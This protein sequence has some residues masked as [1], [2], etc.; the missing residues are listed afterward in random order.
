M[1]LRKFQYLIAKAKGETKGETK[2]NH[3]HPASDYSPLVKNDPLV[4]Y[5]HSFQKTNP[6]TVR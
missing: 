2:E 3:P 1:Y 4:L 6:N 5:N